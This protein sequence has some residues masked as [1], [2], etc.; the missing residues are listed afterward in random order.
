LNPQIIITPGAEADLDDAFQWY[1]EKSPGLGEDFIHCVDASLTSI[2]YNPWQYQKVYKN[3]RRA[4]TH[5]FPYGI[6]YIIEESRIVVLAVLHAKRD[7]KLW[8][9]RH[10]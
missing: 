9:M 4:L 3:I 10:P 5:R 2:Q 7:P 1:E 6:F 8:K